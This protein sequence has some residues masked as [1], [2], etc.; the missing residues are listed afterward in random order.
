MESL[1][2]LQA[3]YAAQCDGDWEHSYGVQVD[4][5]D[6]PGWMLKVDIRDT[7]LDG[8]PFVEVKDNYDHETDW[9]RCW[10]EDAAFHG[11]CGP[12][13][14]GDVLRVFLDWAASSE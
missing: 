12:L 4:T 13:R 10:L 3:W 11:A 6:N 1:A 9:M 7:S 14:L 5:L 8:M 2:G